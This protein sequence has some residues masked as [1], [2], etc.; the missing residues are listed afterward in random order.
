VE[1]KKRDR[2]RLDRGRD[3]R[4][5]RDREE[6]KIDKKNKH[7]RMKND[8]KKRETEKIDRKDLQSQ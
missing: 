2:K 7:R 8:L 5:V 6:G 3:N 4:Q 1:R